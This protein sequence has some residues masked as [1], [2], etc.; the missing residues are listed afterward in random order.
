MSERQVIAIV[1]VALFFLGRRFLWWY[2]G[3][4]AAGGPRFRRELGAPGGQG[5][6]SKPDD[7][8]WTIGPG[9]CQRCG[10]YVPQL[11]RRPWGTLWL[12]DECAED[13]DDKDLLE[14]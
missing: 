3:T 6:M 5:Q 14:P 13:E 7:W 8:V 11:V 1:L 9:E 2:C 10:V 4:P 12:C